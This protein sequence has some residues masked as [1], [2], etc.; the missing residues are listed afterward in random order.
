MM[1]KK[2]RVAKTRLPQGIFTTTVKQLL[3]DG[4]GFAKVD[5]KATMI[6][7]ALPNETVEFTYT[8]Q[9]KQLLEGQTT[10]V[11]TASPDRVTPKC[12]VFNQCGGCALQHL[13]TGK[14]I[15]FKTQQLLGNLRK[16]AGLSA[17]IV[18]APLTAK[19][20]GYRRR[21]R[22]GIKQAADKKNVLVGFRGRLSSYIVAMS[23]CETLAPELSN[24]LT[25]IASLIS[26]MS[27][28]DRIP[29][30]EMILGDLDNHSTQVALSF[31]HLA[32]LTDD[33]LTRF[34]A[35][36]E[37]Y[38][39]DIYLQAEGEETLTGLNHDK[40]I[41]YF[42]D[43]QTE[44]ETQAGTSSARLVM[45]FL[46]Y[47]FTQVN[48]EMNQKMLTQALNWLDLQAG[49]NVLDLFCGLGN[50]TLP[51]AQRVR[52]VV[53]VEGAK[54]LVDWAKRNAENNAID[55]ATFYQADLTQD[56]SLM[57]W[58]VKHQYNKVLIDPP[59][60]GAIEI[61]PLIRAIAPEKICYVSCHPA[62]LARDIDILVNQYGYRLTQVGT[63]FTHTAHVESMALLEKC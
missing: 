21:A 22:V 55:N 17:K 29:Q 19:P 6:V 7:G 63:M 46:P 50:F 56:T 20:W 58:R 1:N 62:T 16:Q 23:A 18:A 40:V 42:I 51:I 37:N 31:R 2:R 15:E 30:V 47:H 52:S 49:D 41:Q 34:S 25:P 24:L 5:G 32:P 44:N 53:G 27:N 9:K 28:P 45:D 14:Q 48:F 12:S 4:R 57:A 10:T 61:M 39:A 33:D 38:C 43:I 26:G 13:Q 54:A 35:F 8:N 59:R 60:A 11:V 36:A 3:T